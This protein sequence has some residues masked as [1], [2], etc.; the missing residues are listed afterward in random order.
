MLSKNPLGL[1]SA[2]AKIEEYSKYGTLPNANNATAHMFI[3]NPMMGIGAS[4]SNLL[5][6]ILVL[7]IV[8]QIEKLSLNPHYRF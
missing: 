1:A 8:L 5:A 4:L 7:R 3:I 2:L 6:H